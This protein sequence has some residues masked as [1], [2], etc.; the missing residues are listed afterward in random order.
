MKTVSGWT[1]D[2]EHH[3]KWLTGY[4]NHVKHLHQ[5]T[6][7]NYVT[8]SLIWSL[9]SCVSVKHFHQ[10]KTKHNAQVRLCPWN[11][12][13][14]WKAITPSHPRNERLRT[15]VPKTSQDSRPVLNAFSPWYSHVFSFGRSNH[16]LD[17]H[18]KS[19][20]SNSHLELCFLEE[21][22]MGLRGGYTRLHEAT[23]LH[24]QPTRRVC[25]QKTLLLTNHPGKKVETWHS[26]SEN[27]FG[28]RE[29]RVK[30]QIFNWSFYGFLILSP[31]PN[32]SDLSCE[33]ERNGNPTINR[34][35]FG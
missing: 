7:E 8:K 29:E 11:W 10:T 22:W 33:D 17:S 6:S 16:D 31:L 12:R 35:C 19:W 28:L 14:T 21:Y 1:V 18:T 27:Q 26:F 25:S 13:H 30:V 32:W 9:P 4:S 34:N 3:T 15:L 23:V 24:K 2:L 5:K 20:Y